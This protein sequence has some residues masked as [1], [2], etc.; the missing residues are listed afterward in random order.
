MYLLTQSS[1]HI[2]HISFHGISHVAVSS[3]ALL[4]SKV[5]LQIT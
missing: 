3:A 2:H 1:C 4:G 5:M